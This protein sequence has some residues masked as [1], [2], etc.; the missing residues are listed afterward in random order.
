MAATDTGAGVQSV[1]DVN[2]APVIP[3]S[4]FAAKPS[5]WAWIWFVL[6]VL[7]ILGFHIRVFGRAIPPAASFP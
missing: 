5:V 6:A 2:T 3:N 7:V 1:L 4:S